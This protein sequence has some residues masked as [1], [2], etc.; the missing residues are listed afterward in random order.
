MNLVG[1]TLA[2]LGG[3]WWSLDIVPEFMRVIGHLS[4]VAWAM[5]AFRKLIF[6]NAALVNILPE[7]GILLAFTAAFFVIG[8]LRFKYD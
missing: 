3:A 4:P 2:P 1:L 5:D 7:L 8:V 6:E